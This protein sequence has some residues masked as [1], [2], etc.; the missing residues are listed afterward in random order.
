MMDSK[1]A[2]LGLFAVTLGGIAACAESTQA[3]IGTSDQ[4]QTQALSAE[5]GNGDGHRPPGPH[6]PPPPEAFDAC[7][8]KTADAACTV[9]H[10]DR[11]MEGKCIT[12]PP[13][14]NEKRL[15]CAP[16]HPPGGPGG[17]PPGGPGG[18]KPVH[19]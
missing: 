7:N 6:H 1:I 4:A 2:V 12:P 8:G 18:P 17:P 5:G 10:G 19:P 14:A 15:L 3:P 13:D 9:T 16:P 11:T